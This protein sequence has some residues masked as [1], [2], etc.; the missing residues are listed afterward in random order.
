MSQS[1]ANPV[2]CQSFGG[3]EAHTG[4]LCH[5][6]TPSSANRYFCRRQVK[7][8]DVFQVMLRDKTI[9]HEQSW[10]VASEPL[11]EE[12]WQ[13]VPQAGNPVRGQQTEPPGIPFLKDHLRGRCQGAGVFFCHVQEKR[14]EIAPSGISSLIIP[15]VFGL[16]KAN[17]G[18]ICPMK[19]PMKAFKPKK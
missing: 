6:P 19:I 12:D 10:L 7:M 11:T 17:Q 16:M 9:R 15:S 13:D 1:W 4:R 14:C 18:T 5:W 3:T 8:R 2:A